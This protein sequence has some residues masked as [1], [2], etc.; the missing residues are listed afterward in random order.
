MQ[1]SVEVDWKLQIREH[2]SQLR[3][4]AL[5]GNVTEAARQ[6]EAMGEVIVAAEAVGE[7]PKGAF[8][9]VTTLT[10]QIRPH[11]ILRRETMVA[12]IVANALA[13][14]GVMGRRSAAA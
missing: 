14:A 1:E 10:G 6:L 7:L 5:V 12:A 9:N 3:N 8:L 11:I 4:Y 13:Q 2:L